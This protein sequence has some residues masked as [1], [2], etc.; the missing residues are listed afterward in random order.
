MFGIDA[1]RTQGL[2]E[3]MP[4]T[5]ARGTFGVGCDS[6]W[7]TVLW[8][9]PAAPIAETSTATILDCC[10]SASTADAS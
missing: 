10:A 4:E 2:V 1:T 3:R 5:R 8:M 6:T 7:S 9:N